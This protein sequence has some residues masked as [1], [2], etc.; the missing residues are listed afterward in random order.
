MSRWDD[1]HGWMQLR[2]LDDGAGLTAAFTIGYRF[3]D[4]SAD[5]WTSRFNAFKNTQKPALYGGLN[6]MTVAVPQLVDGLR[7]ERSR[8]I[9]VPAIRSR[10]SQA[11]RNDTLSIIGHKAAESADVE[12]LID[13]VQKQPHQPLHTLHSAEGR[14]DALDQAGYECTAV[15]ADNILIFD[16]FI[17][18]G[19]TQSRI[20]RAVLGV[21]PGVRVYGI[22]LCKTE[23]RDYNRNVYGVE[24]SNDHVPDKWR[25]L[26]DKGKDR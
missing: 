26:W 17:T 11:S 19:S 25:R 8:T 5:D 21:N 9:L 23:R 14:S 3:T 20:A 22:A 2:C 12:F 13:A 18:R 4:D 16:D 6:V 24:L 1:F 15:D 7:L 10:E